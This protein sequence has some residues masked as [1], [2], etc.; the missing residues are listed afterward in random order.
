[1]TFLKV[2]FRPRRVE[3]EIEISGSLGAGT[4]KVSRPILALGQRQKMSLVLRPGKA[5]GSQLCFLIFL[6]N[7]QTCPEVIPK[8]VM[9]TPVLKLIPP[10]ELLWN[11]NFLELNL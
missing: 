1:M 7:I 6:L 8:G 11:W 5:E 4:L 2:L 9:K 3:Q 10:C